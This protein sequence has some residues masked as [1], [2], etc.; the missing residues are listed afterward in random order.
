MT[1][2]KRVL[3]V[4]DDKS[5]LEST[6]RL[7]VL[8]GHQVDTATNYIDGQALLNKNTYALIISD[9]RMP[10]GQEAQ[11]H[12]TAGIE[13]LAYAWWQEKHKGV[14]LVLYTGDDSD[15]LKTDLAEFGAHYLQKP[16]SE[17]VDIIRKLMEERP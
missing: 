7:L 9:N 16:S 4:E 14:P 17:F 3:L 2:Q 5:V 13:L 11:L 10:I 8:M 15:K 12:A 6:K 1:S